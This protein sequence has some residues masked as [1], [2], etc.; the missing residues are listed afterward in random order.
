MAATKI[1]DSARCPAEHGGLGGCRS[2]KFTG[3]G[4]SQLC[5]IKRNEWRKRE[6]ERIRAKNESQKG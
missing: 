1:D 5:I 4:P 3:G 6:A 2:C